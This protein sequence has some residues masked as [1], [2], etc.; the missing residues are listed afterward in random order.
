MSLPSLSIWRTADVGFQL[1]QPSEDVQAIEGVPFSCGLRL[2]SPRKG[3]P[4]AIPR[5]GQRRHSGRNSNVGKHL[6]DLAIHIDSENSQLLD[7]GYAGF[8]KSAGDP[9]GVEVPRW[10]QSNNNS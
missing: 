3:D 1:I 9:T 8:A 7:E 10:E 4:H 5:L 2:R 6:C